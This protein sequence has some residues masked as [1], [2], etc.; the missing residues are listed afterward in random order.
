MS[1]PLLRTAYKEILHTNPPMGDGVTALIGH[2]GHPS[3]TVLDQR[4]LDH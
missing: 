2:L 3:M 1:V 4:P